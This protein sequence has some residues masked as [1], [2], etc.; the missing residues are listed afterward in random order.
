MSLTIGKDLRVP[1]PPSIPE[2]VP[3]LRVTHTRSLS[4]RAEDFQRELEERVERWT[5][6]F[7][8]DGERRELGDRI[9]YLNDR[10]SLEVFVPSESIWW[11]DRTT[12]FAETPPSD[13]LP[14]PGEAEELARRLLRELDVQEDAVRPRGVST[15][16][17]ATV[18]SPEERGEL[19]P[20]AVTV[21]FGYALADLPVVGPGARIR[22]TY[23]GGG[24]LAEFARF[25]RRPEETGSIRLIDPAQAV[26]RLADDPRFAGVPNSGMIVEVQ[27]FALA[28]YAAGPAAFQRY[29]VPVYRARGEVLG[30]QV[31]GDVFD[32]YI[33]AVDLDPVEL[34]DRAVRDRPV[35]RRVFTGF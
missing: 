23:S 33:T 22:A 6:A 17:A 15:V 18:G 2:S 29:L 28:F 7:P 21:T 1:E 27:E 5:N 8:V 11:S 9:L 10:A 31:E 25:W 24:Q 34:K 35:Y 4:R 16:N 32:V 3:V 19:T 20:T 12:A 26:Q 30:S 13:P 14:S